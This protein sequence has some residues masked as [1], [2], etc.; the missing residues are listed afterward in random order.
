MPTSDPDVVTCIHC[1]A[2]FAFTESRRRVW[3]LESGHLPVDSEWKRKAPQSPPLVA[4]DD[5]WDD[6]YEPSASLFDT[7]RADVLRQDTSHSTVQPTNNPAA[8]V[9]P[10][11]TAAAPMRTPKS[12]GWLQWAVLMLGIGMFTC[13]AILIAWSFRAERHDLWNIGAPLAL[14]G[15]IAFLVGLIMHLEL[16]WRHSAWTSSQVEHLHGSRADLASASSATHAL[17]A[18]SETVASEPGRLFNELKGSLD[19][20]ATQISRRNEL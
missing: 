9:V 2:T 10:A 11:A 5:D 13:G 19:R 15:Q 16:L 7:H 12:T 1:R 20:I 17:A 18:R 8:Q 6:M 3:R 4:T 14:A